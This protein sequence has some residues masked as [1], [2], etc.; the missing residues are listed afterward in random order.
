MNSSQPQGIL[1]AFVEAHYYS[2]G[3]CYQHFPR[4]VSRP[5]WAPASDRVGLRNEFPVVGNACAVEWCRLLTA[6]GDRVTWIALYRSAVDA[7]SGN[8]ENHAGIGVWLRGP[9]QLSAT[10]LLKSLDVALKETKLADGK[11]SPEDDGLLSRFSEWLKTTISP[12]ADFGGGLNHGSGA[13]R[14][15]KIWKIIPSDQALDSVGRHI[16][17]LSHSL[18]VLNEDRYLYAVTSDTQADFEA[19]PSI[20]MID[21]AFFQDISSH[22]A[23]MRRE[24]DINVDR[25]VRLEARKAEL[26]AQIPIAQEKIASLESDAAALRTTLAAAKQGPKEIMFQ[27][28]DQ[29]MV[30]L[31]GLER[32]VDALGDQAAANEIIAKLDRIQSAIGRLEKYQSLPSTPPVFQGNSPV[33]NYGPA[34]RMPALPPEQDNRWSNAEKGIVAVF[35]IVVTAIVAALAWKFWPNS[36]AVPVDP[37]LEASAYPY[38]LS[39]PEQRTAELEKSRNLVDSYHTLAEKGDVHAQGNLGLAYYNGRGVA[40]DYIQAYKWFSLVSASAAGSEVRNQAIKNRD[41]VAAKMSRDQIAEAQR[42]AREW[43]KK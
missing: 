10:D 14:Q 28:R 30:H 41:I 23:K 6:S 4:S 29:I 18:T 33:P 13:L 40:R 38:S 39:T 15:S 24:H 43:R 34:Q 5:S 17:A 9:V 12:S 16:R 8:R 27:T 32:R 20:E 42:L 36:P 31:A 37:P 26:E 19:V 2:N 3:I 22:L 7:L 25:C 21:A 1:D 11:L 35:V